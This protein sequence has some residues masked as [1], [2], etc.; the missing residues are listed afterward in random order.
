MALPPLNQVPFQ[1]I[2]PA[3]AITA[4]GDKPDGNF[5]IQLNL[6]LQAINQSINAIV[7]AFNAA[8]AAQATADQAQTSADGAQT[9]ADGAQAG[10]D[11]LAADQYIIAAASPDLM[12]ARVLTDTAFV[13]KNIATAG[14]LK[15]IV[16]A[17]GILNLATV[18]LTQNLSTSGSASVGA[19]LTVTGLTTTDSLRINGTVVTGAVVQTGSVVINIAGTNVRFLTG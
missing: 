4:K 8:Q 1:G 17:L 9:T 18:A 16:D 14:Q 5:L 15:I 3:Y 7:I 19:G 6:A 13:T 11:T 2:N 10:V 12:N